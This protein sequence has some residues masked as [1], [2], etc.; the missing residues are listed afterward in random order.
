MIELVDAALGLPE[1]PGQRVRSGYLKV[2]RSRQPNGWDC[3]PSHQNSAGL[4]PER[5]RTVK[6]SA[7][8]HAGPTG[9]QVVTV[10]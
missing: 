3:S 6:S 5:F 7:G 2:R 8:E 10:G 9:E 4:D 1:T